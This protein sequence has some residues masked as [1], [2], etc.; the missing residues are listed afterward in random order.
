MIDQELDLLYNNFLEFTDHMVGQYDPMA[1]AGVMMAQALSIY[2]TAMTEDDYNEMVDAISE[3]R[4]HVKKFEQ[5][6]LQ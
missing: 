3:K 6:V 2:R 5:V 1:V 4:D